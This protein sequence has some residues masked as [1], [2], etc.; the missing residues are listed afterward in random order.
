MLTSLPGIYALEQKQT[1]APRII[2]IIE[3]NAK[4]V[5]L[6]KGGGKIRAEELFGISQ[7]TWCWYLW[8]FSSVCQKKGLRF[9][10]WRHCEF[11]SGFVL[12][13]LILGKPNNNSGFQIPHP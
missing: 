7:I 1:W 6:A 2:M 4:D 8:L 3:R 13:K 11:Y 9:S 10:H 5:E 12:S